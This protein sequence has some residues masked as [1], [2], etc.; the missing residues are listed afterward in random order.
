MDSTYNCTYSTI[1]ESKIFSKNCK[2]SYN[3]WSGRNWWF[4]FAICPWHDWPLARPLFIG[5]KLFIQTQGSPNRISVQTRSHKPI[6]NTKSYKYKC[7]QKLF[8]CK[9]STFKRHTSSTI[10]VPKTVPIFNLTRCP[11]RVNYK[12]VPL[13]SS[14]VLLIFRSKYS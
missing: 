1:C 2:M 12:T 7:V 4:W 5:S 6:S 9:K 14:L 10:T 8:F 3:W 13:A 11:I